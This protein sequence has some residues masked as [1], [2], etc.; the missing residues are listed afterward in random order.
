M[1]ELF[2]TKNKK[3]KKIE[4]HSISESDMSWFI[5]GLKELSKENHLVFYSN[6]VDADV[7][8][9]KGVI[10]T[11]PNPIEAKAAL[12]RLYDVSRLIHNN[13]TFFV[14]VKEANE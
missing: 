7:N 8:Y 2:R 5:E 6:F 10:D 13:F 14:K 12:S 3:T 9:L 4:V 11:M 1:L